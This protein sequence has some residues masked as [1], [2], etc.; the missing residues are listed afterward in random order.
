[1]IKNPNYEANKKIFNSSKL[2]IINVLSYTD[3]FQSSQ[4]ILESIITPGKYQIT[5]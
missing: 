4:L 3:T 2:K 1:M 5:S